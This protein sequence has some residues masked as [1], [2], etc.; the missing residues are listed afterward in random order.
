MPILG[1]TASQNYVRIPPGAYES[2]ATFTATG[3][4]TSFTFSSIPSTYTS[5]QIRGIGKSNFASAASLWLYLYFNGDTTAANYANHQLTGDGS[6]VTASGSTLTGQIQVGPLVSNAA[7]ETSMFGA[8]IIDIHDYAST[9]KNK[10]V[11]SIGGD[12]RNSTL[13]RV[14]LDSGLW[15]STAA[16]TSITLNRPGFALMSGSVFSLYGIAG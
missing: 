11:R 6:A 4:E 10:T 14:E 8:M 3:S 7:G 16:V 2:I 1:I 12:N 13:G 5:L 15:L 9:T